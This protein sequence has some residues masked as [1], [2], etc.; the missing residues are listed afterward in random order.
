MRSKAESSR[1]RQKFWTTFGQYMRPIPSA[2]GLKVNWLNYKTGHRKLFF[3]MDADRSGAFIGIVM[4]MKDRAL[5][6]LYFEQFEILK[7][8]LHTQLGEEW[9]WE[10]HYSLGPGQQV[11]TIY[12][13]QAE[14]NIYRESDWP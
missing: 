11:H 6:A 10:T 8:A 1:I 7:T 13:R 9:C 2:D 12:R 3:R 4:A 5:Q 14:L